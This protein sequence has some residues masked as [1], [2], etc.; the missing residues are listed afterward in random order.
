[1]E[2]AEGAGPLGFVWGVDVEG[3]SVGNGMTGMGEGAGVTLRQCAEAIWSAGVAAVDSARLVQSAVRCQAGELTI[4]G[5]TLPLRDID[6]I[7]VVGGG[8]AGAGMAAGLEAALGPEVLTTKVTGWLNVPADCVRE[9]QVIHL[10]AGRPA[11][12]N[13]PVAAGVAGTT[14]ILELA[15]SMTRRDLCLVLLSGGGSALLPAPAAGITLEDKQ[16]VTR[17][18]MQSGASIDEL[19]AVRSCLSRFKG[20]GLLRAIPAGR[21]LALIISDVIDDPLPVIASGP[22]VAQRPDPRRALSILEARLGTDQ[23]PDRVRQQ[24]LTSVTTADDATLAAS[25][26]RNVIIGNNQ[27]AVSAAAAQARQLGFEVAFEVTNQAGIARDVGRD[28]ARACNTW[29]QR[30][31]TS[32]GWCLISGGEPVVQMVPTSQPRKGGRNQE[33]VLAAGRELWDRVDDRCVVLS[34]GTDGEDGPT[35]AAGA[36]FDAR[37]FRRAVDRQ[38][39]PDPYLEINNAYPFFDATGGL[40]KTGPTHTNVMDLRIALVVPDAAVS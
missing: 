31:T 17:G 27:T 12:L 39:H 22:T 13:E 30:A 1:M 34:G 24:L 2:C 7:L 14:R 28:L 16:Q 35:D 38:L 11:G 19:N 33:L 21:T 37:V 3:V 25:A 32:R 23:I 9:L 29:R 36:V 20:G 26:C 6:R 10:H 5:E 4:A 40:L 8:K 18:L 15:G